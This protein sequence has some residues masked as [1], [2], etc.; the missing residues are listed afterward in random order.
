MSRHCGQMQNR[1]QLLAGALRYVTLGL[2]TAGGAAT[3][4]KRNRLMR[5]GKCINSGICTC[6]KVL[7]QCGLPQALSARKAL[8]GVNNGRR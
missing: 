1:R 3:F 8:T 7:K 2:L 4:A 6:C 5:E